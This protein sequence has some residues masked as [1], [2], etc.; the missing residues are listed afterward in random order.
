[1]TTESGNATSLCYKD[2]V[3]RKRSSRWSHG[4]DRKAKSQ[5]EAS[6]PHRPGGRCLSAVRLA[7]EHG[8]GCSGKYGYED[9]DCDR[10]RTGA[11]NSWFDVLLFIFIPILV[12]VHSFGSDAEESLS[13]SNTAN[14]T[15]V[16]DIAKIADATEPSNAAV[17]AQLSHGTLALVAGQDGYLPTV[18]GAAGR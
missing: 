10:K 18:A 7:A 4:T 13:A 12:G 5:E 9:S 11:C 6:A 14:A 17:T 3:I 2:V 1:M 8:I 16:A 15:N